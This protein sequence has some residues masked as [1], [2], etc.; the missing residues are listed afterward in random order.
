MTSLAERAGRGHA[1]SAYKAWIERQGIPVATG[2]GITDLGAPAF[3]HWERLGCDAYFVQL[4]GMEGFTGM[5]VAQLPAGGSTKLE[6]HL[7]EKVVHAL[8][9]R[10]ATTLEGPDGSSVQFE[11][12]EGSLFAIPLN[13]PH[14]FF[15]LRRACTD[16]DPA[17]SKMFNEALARNGI[18]PW[19]P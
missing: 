2:H 19:K 3:V 7:Y 11:W 18:E 10:G 6:H 12:Q 9:G 4:Q 8:R 13:T 5:Y 14:R 17:I 16:E 1:P 15:R